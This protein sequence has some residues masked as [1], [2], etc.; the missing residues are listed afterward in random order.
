MQKNIYPKLAIKCVR[1]IVH[2]PRNLGI[3]FVYRMPGDILL[4]D[5]FPNSEMID[6]LGNFRK[7]KKIL[8]VSHD[9]DQKLFFCQVVNNYESSPSYQLLIYRLQSLGN[10]NAYNLSKTVENVV[11]LKKNI[12]R[13]EECYTVEQICQKPSYKYFLKENLKILKKYSENYPIIMWKGSNFDSISND[14][15]YQVGFNYHFLNLI[16]EEIKNFGMKLL[17]KGVPKCLYAENNYFQIADYTLKNV[18]FPNFP[19]EK[20]ENIDFLFKIRNKKIN[21]QRIGFLNKFEEGHFHELLFIETFRVE[22]KCLESFAL[23]SKIEQEYDYNEQVIKAPDQKMNVFLEN[24][25]YK[26]N[27]LNIIEKFYPNLKINFVEQY[28][29]QQNL[30]C[31]FKHLE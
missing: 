26:E 30:R 13:I 5:D 19:K 20:G 15:I 21:S 12:D 27:K 18:F 4:N 2:P 22:K 24:D 8:S 6:I 31:I 28:E 17:K 11:G 29:D 25:S 14:N 3:R 7:F 16:G 23:N 10:I 1:L 9:K